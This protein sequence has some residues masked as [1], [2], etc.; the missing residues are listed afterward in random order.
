MEYRIKGKYVNGFACVKREDGLWNYMDKT[1]HLLSPNLW[2]LTIH[3]FIGGFAKVQRKDGLWNYINKKGQLLSP[4]QWFREAAFFLNGCGL[5]MNTDKKCG[6]I[7]SNGKIRV[8]MKF[9]EIY[10]SNGYFIGTIGY[11]RYA[12]DLHFNIYR[13]LL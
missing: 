8:D 7:D 11:I 3:E 1:R 4:N 9:D 6:I 10:Y 12:I 13:L 2:F 5:V